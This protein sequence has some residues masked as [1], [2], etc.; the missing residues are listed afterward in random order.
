M[1]IRTRGDVCRFAVVLSCVVLLG[2]IAL[3]YLLLPPDLAAATLLP[4]SLMA[5]MLTTPL[6][7]AVGQR[8]QSAHQLSRRLE[9][10][11]HHDLL[12]GVCTRISFHDRA[13]RLGPVPCAV[14]LADIDHFKGFNDHYGHQA[15]DQ[16]LRQFAAIIASNCR[17][18]DIVA[19]FGGE[20][21]V[22]VLRNTTPE[23]GLAAARRLCQ[24]TRASPVVIDGQARCLTASFGVA[25]LPPGGEIELAIQQ[26]DRALYRAKHDGRDRACL[27]D[28]DQDAAPLPLPTAA[29]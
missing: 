11:L 25:L 10:A 2:S 1:Q 17:H 15:G 6:A 7:Y 3:R 16:A 24:R 29:E 13:A 19:R 27:H 28:P 9:H 5:L 22:L 23:D 8:L 20:E 21:F 12:T 26:A 4:G 18:D 14:I